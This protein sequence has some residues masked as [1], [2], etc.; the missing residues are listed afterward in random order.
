LATVLVVL[1]AAVG[2]A[3]ALKPSGVIQAAGA[4]PVNPGGYYAYATPDDPMNPP[5]AS[6]PAGSWSWTPSKRRV[7]VGERWKLNGR[8]WRVTQIAAM[9]GVEPIGGSFGING[10]PLA[11]ER[12]AGNSSLIM[13]GRLVLS[14]IS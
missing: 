5:A 6:S 7:S 2:A 14:P 9:P 4:C 3:V 10:W 13:C 12:I 1:V 11:G 8:L